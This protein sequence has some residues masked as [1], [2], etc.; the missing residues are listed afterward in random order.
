MRYCSEPPTR[1]GASH[2]RLTASADQH[3]TSRYAATVASTV[4]SQPPRPPARALRHPCRPVGEHRGDRRGDR[5]DVVRIG[6]RGCARRDL[7]GR[8]AAAGDHRRP[9]RHRLED[10]HAEP[11]LQAGVRE[12]GR[13]QR[14]AQAGR[15][16]RRNRGSGRGHQRARRRPTRWHPATSER[17]RLVEPRHGC[18]EP[19][20]VLAGLERA[21][22]QHEAVGQGVPGAHPREV[23]VGDGVRVDAPRDDP[24]TAQRRTRAGEVVGGRPAR[25]E[26]EVGGAAAFEPGQHHPYA[27]LREPVGRVHERD[28]VDGDD[29][30][31]TC[32]RGDRDRRVAHVDRAG[33]ALDAGAAEAVPR[34]V[35]PRT[36]DRQLAHRE[37]RHER[38][39]GRGAVPSGHTDHLDVV[40]S[41]ESSE[42]LER[43]D[44]RATG[45]VVP[46]LLQRVGD[47][48]RLWHGNIMPGGGTVTACSSA[49][50][51]GR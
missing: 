46:A 22:E 7:L 34:L 10:R 29:V 45:D 11:L 44:G 23:V 2:S 12:H 20:Q 21:D 9:V 31:C 37:R 43:G 27:V 36:A 24:H 3:A 1:P 26:Q 42:H 17:D 5:V 41:H 39:G 16:R 19:G 40:A 14:R 15:R 8:R 32:R 49:S 50:S 28:V 51:A 35:E 47:A 6:E 38:V 13:R 25:H 30:R 4:A 33:G 18:S 48:E